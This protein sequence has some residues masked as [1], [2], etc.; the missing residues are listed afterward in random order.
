[1]N[2]LC[3]SQNTSFPKTGMIVPEVPKDWTGCPSHKADRGWIPSRLHHG[4]ALRYYVAY[5][6]AL[7]TPE[8]LARM[9]TATANCKGQAGNGTWL[10]PTTWSS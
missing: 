5:R 3:E 7:A 9:G 1:M 4:P 2:Q 10:V 6:K 8:E